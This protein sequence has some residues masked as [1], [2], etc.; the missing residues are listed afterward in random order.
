MF[1]HIGFFGE[2]YKIFR[3]IELEI[4]IKVYDDHHGI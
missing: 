4:E 3:E 2:D 1:C